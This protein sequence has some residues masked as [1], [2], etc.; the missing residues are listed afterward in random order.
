[1][2]CVRALWQFCEVYQY[3]KVFRAKKIECFCFLG[4]FGGVFKFVFFREVGKREKVEN[5]EGTPINSRCKLSGN[6]N[7]MLCNLTLIHK[8]LKYV[9]CHCG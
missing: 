2:V 4:I 1:M 9:T 3:G 8:P 5:G 6:R 7:Y